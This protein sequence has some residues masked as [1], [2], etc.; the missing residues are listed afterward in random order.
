MLADSA[1]GRS[2]RQWYWCRSLRPTRQ[3]GQRPAQELP[4]AA[5]PSWQRTVMLPRQLVE[6]PR[7]EAEASRTQTAEAMTA[8][9]QTTP[10]RTAEARTQ[11]M[12]RAWQK[13]GRTQAV[14]RLRYSVEA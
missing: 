5:A 9:P 14:T 3:A 8:P 10:A 11:R 13:P 4:W 12:Q 2:E 7:V 1:R 6:A